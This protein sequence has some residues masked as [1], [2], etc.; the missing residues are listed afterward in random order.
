VTYLNALRNPRLRF[1]LRATVNALL[2]FGLAHVLAVSFHGLWAVIP[3]VV[4]IQTSIGGSLKATAEYTIG[5]IAGAVYA[6]AV[7]AV[8]FRANRPAQLPAAASLS[9]AAVSFRHIRAIGLALALLWQI[10]SCRRSLHI[11][12]RQYGHRCGGG[13]AKSARMA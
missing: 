3:A 2:A 10:Y 1:C 6:G 7:A 8:L 4:M 11:H 5:T 9:R 13:R 12:F